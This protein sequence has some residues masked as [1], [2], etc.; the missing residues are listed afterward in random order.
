MERECLEGGENRFW[1][2]GTAEIR[3]RRLVSRRRVAVLGGWFVW[4]KK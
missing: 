1:R 4:E 3:D 2:C